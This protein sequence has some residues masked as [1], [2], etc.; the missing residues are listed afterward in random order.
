VA[1]VVWSMGP[2]VE[3]AAGAAE[4]VV[5]ADTPLQRE[6]S[7]VSARIKI[8]SRGRRV[9]VDFVVSSS[10][11]TWCRV[12]EIEPAGAEGYVPCMALGQATVAASAAPP[13][14]DTSPVS[15]AVPAF[16]GIPPP[17]VPPRF[18][19][20][21]PGAAP[22]PS[23]G[24]AS[25]SPSALPTQDGPVPPTMRIDV[26]K[27]VN[28]ALDPD[29]SFWAKR[30]GLT[31]AQRRRAVDVSARTGWRDC[32]LQ[33]RSVPY[34]APWSADRCR[35]SFALFWRD[36][37]ALLTKEQLGRLEADERAVEEYTGI[38]VRSLYRAE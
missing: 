35:P 33:L 6:S 15:T 24:P 29:P 19:A 36:F 5:T 4:A 9:V 26:W 31:E 10:R 12:R 1:L 17:A 30:L 27:L 21:V 28:S 14:A 37:T 2:G 18:P 38:R 3:P 13:P 23:S 11:G 32:H 16:R 22:P 8:L 7:P 25:M 34:G 20:P